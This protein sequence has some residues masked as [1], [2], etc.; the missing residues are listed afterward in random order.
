MRK[1]ER[2]GLAGRTGASR[3]ICRSA[4]PT[5]RRLGERTDI[6][7]RIHEGLAK[8][9]IERR[10][11]DYVLEEEDPAKPIIGRR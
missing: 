10:L 6:V 2:L 4:P 7:K 5:L 11:S 1:L 9:H 3:C 8:L